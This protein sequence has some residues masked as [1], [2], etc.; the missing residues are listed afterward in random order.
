MKKIEAEKG[1]RYLCHEWRKKCGYQEV[2]NNQL[3]ASEFISWLKKNHPEYLSF[4]CTMGVN[5][6]IELWFDQEFGLT[7]TR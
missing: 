4:R 7:W 2:D 1:C 6:Q 5:Y 3:H